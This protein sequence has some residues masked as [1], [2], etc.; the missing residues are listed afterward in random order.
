M[1]KSLTPPARV[2]RILTIFG[3]LPLFIL[4]PNKIDRF[5]EREVSEEG[6]KLAEKLACRY[7][8]TSAKMS[9]SVQTVFFD[10]VR[11]LRGS[12]LMRP[13]FDSEVIEFRQRG[14]CSNVTMYMNFEIM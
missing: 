13:N 3:S 2:C 8:E 6:Q 5:Y 7:I 11:M 12:K 10:I 1:C 9:I 4:V 14:M